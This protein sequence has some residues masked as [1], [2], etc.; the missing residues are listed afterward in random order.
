MNVVTTVKVATL[1]PIATLVRIATVGWIASLHRQHKPGLENAPQRKAMAHR[2]LRALNAST[3]MK[4]KTILAKVSGVAMRQKG[5]RLGATRATLMV[6]ARAALMAIIL[7]ATNATSRH[8]AAKA[9]ACTGHH[10]L[11]K[12]GA[13]HANPERIRML[14][15]ITVNPRASR[16]FSVAKARRFGLLPALTA[17]LVQPANLES[18]RTLHGPRIVTA[19]AKISRPAKKGSMLKAVL[20]KRK[21]RAKAV[22]TANTNLQ[23]MG[24]L[25]LPATTKSHALQGNTSWVGV[26]LPRADHATHAHLGN[27]RQEALP[28]EKSST[29]KHLARPN[30]PASLANICRVRV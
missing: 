8:N 18:I 30:P 14:R 6:I 7:K 29:G 5:N 19:L 27:T 15:H 13:R 12:A 23:T 11:A 10:Q 17:G 4:E 22:R 21:E 2:A 3:M 24:T 26:T 20:P 1:E 28:G 25:T 16:T 9:N